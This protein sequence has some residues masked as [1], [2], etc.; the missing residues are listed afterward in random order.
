VPRTT[1]FDAMLTARDRELAE[2]LRRS[3]EHLAERDRR[4]AALE[5]ELRRLR[6]DAG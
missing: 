3:A 5:A 1:E 6:G 4:L 2:Q